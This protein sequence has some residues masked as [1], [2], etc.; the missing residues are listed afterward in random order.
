MDLW[1][2]YNISIHKIKD[3]VNIITLFVYHY[4]RLRNTVPAKFITSN[5][6]IPY[7]LRLD[8]EYLTHGSAEFIKKARFITWLEDNHDTLLVK[9]KAVSSVRQYHGNQNFQ[10]AFTDIIQMVLHGPVRLFGFGIENRIYD[11]LML[12]G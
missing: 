2:F 9:L 1:F 8:G 10:E 4:N 5:A 11:F 7:T 3:K 12:I 6:L